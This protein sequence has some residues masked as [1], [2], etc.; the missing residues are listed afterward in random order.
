MQQ[1]KRTIFKNISQIS[2]KEIKTVKEIEAV[3]SLDE[4]LWSATGASL[5][6]IN[7]DPFFVRYMD[8]DNNARIMCFEVKEAIC[9]TLKNL[10]NTEGLLKSS[11]VLALDAINTNHKEGRDIKISASQVLQRLGETG[12]KKISLEQIRIIKEKILNTPLSEAGVILP[13]AASDET[14]RCYLS[15][16]IATVGGVLHPCG[17]PGVNRGKLDEFVKNSRQYLQWFRRGV[18]PEHENTSKVMPLGKETHSAFSA[19]SAI[20]DKID[21]YF[22]LCKLLA[23]SRQMGII[24]QSL[25]GEAD[26]KLKKLRLPDFLDPVKVEEFLSKAPIAVPVA[27]CQLSFDSCINGVFKRAVRN[28]KEKV[29]FPLINKA[30]GK[31]TEDEWDT[32]KQTFAE[33]EKWQNEKKGNIVESLDANILEK[34]LDDNLITTVQN[35]IAESNETALVLEEIR[36]IEKIILYQMWLLKFLNNFVYFPYLYDP[37][38]RA[39]FEMGTLI[40]DGR[41]FHLSVRVDNHEKH[42]EIS[43]H[44]NMFVLYVHVL[45]I[46]EKKYEVA[47]PV[48]SGGKGNLYIGKRGIFHDVQ[49]KDWD[50]EIIDIVENPISLYEALVRPFKN[51]TRLINSKIE[52][53][54]AMAESK[55]GTVVSESKVESGTP[56]Q[57]KNPVNQSPGLGNLFMG[58]SIAIAALGSGFAFITRTLSEV[59]WYTILFTIAG[60]FLA[61]LIPTFISAFIKLKNR[62]MTTILE[63]SGWANNVRMNLTFKLG[64][65]FT[66]KPS[67]PLK[68]RRYKLFLFIIILLIIAGCITGLVFLAPYLQKFIASLCT[69]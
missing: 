30:A 41:Q 39:M 24:D 57:G 14:I 20:K 36:I 37:E 53:I 54:K 4:A 40:M 8:M 50:A 65:F 63:A 11:E 60:A 64:K 49:G 31:L 47:I 35:L 51:F 34:Y 44:S 7:C 38:R 19:F 32:I 28:F 9:W 15:D 10:R 2:Q 42:R 69:P 1:S 45:S 52:E 43:R 46:K 48:T 21:Q 17:T 55:L 23:F 58:G 6:A 62:D 33:Y 66:R 5:N 26:E 68:V 16:I 22:R 29:I 67:P 3:L 61:V 56:E 12:E 27:E 59:Q 25:A 13:E 18:I